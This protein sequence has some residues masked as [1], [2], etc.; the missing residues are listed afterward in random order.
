LDTTGQ[1]RPRRLGRT[2]NLALTIVA[3]AALVWAAPVVAA[4]GHGSSG[5]VSLKLKT[6]AQAA[7][8]SSGKVKVSAKAKAK[9]KAVL[10]LSLSQG[11]EKTKV[12]KNKKASLKKKRT[13]ITLK[14]ND[15]GKRLVQSCISTKLKAAAKT[16]G[17]KTLDTAKA[18]MKQDPTVCNGSN[19][20]GVDLSAAD[21]CDFITQPGEECLFPYPND[22]FTR[23]DS[24]TDTG[25]RLNL[26]IASTP[27][28]AGGTHIDPADINTSDGYSPGALVVLHVPGMD[29]PAAFANTGAVPITHEGA[30]FDP[31]Q[32]IVLID[33]QTGQRQLIWS[34]L[35]SNATSPGETD[36]LIH[37]AK[38][39]QDG[40]RYIVALRNLK[41]GSGAVIPAPTGF[42]LYRDDIP[43]DVPAIESRRAHFEDLFQT[44]GTAGIARD[45]LYM[46]WDFTVASTRNLSERMLSIRNDGLALLG[47]TTP[48]DGIAQGSAPAFTVTPGGNTHFYGT[49]TTGRGA[50][51]IATVEGTF[52][53]PCYLNQTGCPSGSRFNLGPNG[54]PQ[55]IPGNFYT[56]RFG[57]NIPRS[58]VTEGPPGTFTVTDNALPTMYGHGLFGEYLEVFSQNIRQLGTENN[59][60]TCATDFI[61]MADEDVFP[62]ALPALQDLSKFEPLPDRLQQGFLDFVY[63]GRLLTQPNGFFN[64][65]AFKVGGVSALDPSNV[66]YYG[67]SQGGIAGGA[68]TAIEPDV[69][70]SVLYVP[71]MNYGGVL[72]TRSVDF[73]DYASV[74]Y[75][76]YQDE[77]ERP[78][79]LSLIQSMWDRGEPNG[80]ANHMTTN[81]LP[82]TPEHKVLIEMAYG[83]H[84]V[85]NAATEVEAR[86]IGAPLRQPALDANRL[87]AGFDQ[88]FFDLAPLGPLPGPAANGNGMFVWDIG[89]KRPSGNPPPNDVLGTDPPPITNTAPN[90]SFGVDPH[91][92]VIRSS[93]LIRAQIATFIKPGGTI[94]D[95][96]GATPCYAAGWMGFP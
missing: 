33:A 2:R 64:D 12:T 74:L 65:P 69:T 44:L 23:S 18:K 53:V 20:V 30:S 9:R 47:D 63:L 17:G 72:L 59:M 29:T 95:P 85:A 49:D 40:H 67:N 21:R 34:E 83:D 62:E 73:E 41:D 87:P 96:C 70:R 94:T 31:A 56:A 93:P 22:Y 80:Y 42:R 75:P 38:N 78:L 8:I 89:P 60:I 46:A 71:G 77:G 32:P 61:G 55:R 91:D 76:S 13:N 48:G 92:T 19:P 10:S 58:A 36:L 4:G 86:T 57:C 28:N 51:D 45:D 82:G 16:K 79:L 37:P 5:K 15:E 52:Q 3:S 88:P 27:A 7:L 66:S 50:Q 35:D 54:L 14:L 24:S 81:P 39:L 11:G 43:T 26:N 6:K 84:Q 90:D 1:G 68:L 25:K